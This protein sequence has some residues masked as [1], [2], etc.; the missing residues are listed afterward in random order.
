MASPRHF[1]CIHGHF[2]QPPR[3]NPWTGKID[4]QPSASPFHDWNQRITSECYAPNASAKVLGPSGAVGETID[5][6]SLISFDFGPTL[7]SW[8]KEKALTT[9]L[10]VLKADRM[11]AAWFSG[12]GSAMAQAY[13]HVIMPLADARTRKTQIIWGMT[14][15]ERRFRRAAE[16]MWLPETAADT[17]TL[18]ALADE[19]VKY[20]VLSPF[21][22]QRTRSE[23]SYGWVDVVGG[24]IDTKKPYIVPLPSGREFTVFFYDGTISHGIAFGQLV[25]DGQSLVD[26]LRSA[27]SEDEGPQ[28]VS[29]ATDGETYGH[30][31]KFGEMA[32]AY[33]LRHIQEGD[34]VHLTNYSEYLAQNR[35]RDYVEILDPSSW[36]CPH[37]VDR[38]KGGC[39]CGSSGSP[40]WSSE[41]RTTLRSSMD[42]LRDRLAL[43]YAEEG[44]RYMSDPWLAVDD[45]A[46]TFFA[47]GAGFER[48]LNEHMKPGQEKARPTVVKLLQM[49]LLAQLMYTSCAWF[50]E[51]ISRIESKQVIA[52]AIR[53]AQLATDVSQSDLVSAF[54]KTLYACK[55]NNANYPDG[56]SVVDEVMGMA[57]GV[58]SVT[59][60]MQV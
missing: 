22:A 43:L 32:L 44:A 37:G 15:F 6:Y 34:E 56:K 36:S 21:Q 16:G 52:Y 39:S 18:E 38:W 17:M 45:Y 51:D 5:N 26:A 25:D 3:E 14:D 55:P 35:P 10:D 19:G 33:C 1:V 4:F 53:A 8:M 24:K 27:F 41:W 29:V 40:S 7:L 23:G 58:G 59:E 42:W 9:Y 20:T 57:P 12:H 50:F 49:E 13:N 28:L 31:H 30:H 48:F 47:D 46:S 60:G 54:A 2:Y 11:S